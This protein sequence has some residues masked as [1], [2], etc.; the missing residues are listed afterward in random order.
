MVFNKNVVALS[1][2]NSFF[3]Q[4]LVTGKHAQVAVM[5][6]PPGGEVGEEVHDTDQVLI[7]VEGEGQAIIAGE[8]SP[9]SADHMV[10][11]PAGTLHNFE[12]TGSV[13]LKLYTLYAP[14]DLK[15][16]TIHTTKAEA[17]AAEDLAL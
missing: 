16:G 2:V 8:R 4:V 10:F 3:R 13:E 17:D 7:F 9:V 6:I 15:P 11:V 12:N 14:P 5:S 1:K